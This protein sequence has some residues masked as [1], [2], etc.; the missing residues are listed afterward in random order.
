MRKAIN[1][2]APVALVDPYRFRPSAFTGES[3]GGLLPR[4]EK[5]TGKV[6]YIH[7]THRVFTVEC[8][9]NGTRL[10]ESFKY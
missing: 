4:I 1:P 7:A 6:V 9:V 5:V 10:R 3:P 8:E 2:P